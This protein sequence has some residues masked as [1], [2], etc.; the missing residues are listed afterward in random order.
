MVN[1]FDDTI[2][3]NSIQFDIT[4]IIPATVTLIFNSRIKESLNFNSRIKETEDLS[5]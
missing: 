3:G 1:L 4:S 2:F 5:I